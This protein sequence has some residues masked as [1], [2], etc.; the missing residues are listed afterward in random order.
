MSEFQYYEFQALDRPLT[1]QERAELRAISSRAEITATS[2]TNEYN[3]GNLK[4]DPAKLVERYFDAHFYLS[5][6]DSR[7]LILRFPVAAVPV[8]VLTPYTLQGTPRAWSTSTHTLVEFNCN[9][10]DIEEC[11]EDQNALADLIPLRQ[12]I[13]S[14]DY[15]CL[16]MAWL[17]GAV[18]NGLADQPSKRITAPPIPPGLGTLDSA[19]ESFADVFWLDRDAIE[20]AARHSPPTTPTQGAKARRALQSFIKGLDIK[21]KDALL[22][23]VALQ[24]QGV[25]A[26]FMALFRNTHAVGV[27]TAAPP[28]SAI[29]QAAEQVRQTRER[30]EAEQARQEAEARARAEAV[31]R[32][33]RRRELRDNWEH[34][35]QTV[36]TEIDRRNRDGYQHA[37]KLISELKDAAT[38]KSC[39]LDFA[40][41]LSTIRTDRQRLTALMN[42][43]KKAG[44]T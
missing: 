12:Q 22:L 44:L 2:F 39:K 1:Q 30:Q 11:W 13:V 28:L 31:R 34:F 29:V 9:E 25:G 38:T 5:N 18:R 32:E 24:E 37:A 42:E 15:R 14:G 33:A 4:A 43:L 23:R 19:L 35:W 41:R 17:D 16:Y 10:E 36:S 20:A 21:T 3:W 7:T 6:W 40:N 27:Q 8:S 26:E